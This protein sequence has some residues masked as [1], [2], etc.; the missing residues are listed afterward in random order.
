MGA[1]VSATGSDACCFA[2]GVLGGSHVASDVD[3]ILV[4]N[5]IN[6]TNTSSN[7]TQGNHFNKDALLWVLL[8][9]W[10]DDI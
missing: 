5:Q 4:N 2:G 6:A 1:G 8:V 9:F 7:K 10:D 3:F